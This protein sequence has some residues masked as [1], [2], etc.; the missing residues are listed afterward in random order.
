MFPNMNLLINKTFINNPW[1][2][3]CSYLWISK[4]IQVSSITEK[5]N[6]LLAISGK[7]SFFI[8]VFTCEKKCTR[9]YT[10]IQYKRKQNLKYWWIKL[11]ENL[12]LMKYHQERESRK[13]QY[14]KLS[15][16]IQSC[17]TTFTYNIDVKFTNW[18]FK[19]RNE[20]PRPRTL[21]WH[22]VKE[23]GNF[24]FLYWKDKRNSCV[25]HAFLQYYNMLKDTHR[26]SSPSNKTQALRKK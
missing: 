3:P 25:C 4:W 22:T 10:E 6:R 23:R 2:R 5:G 21:V 20:L 17:A 16:L 18:S 15:I 12:I 24:I 19:K 26:E 14:R 1:T 13:Q 8:W 11:D 9:K 7:Y